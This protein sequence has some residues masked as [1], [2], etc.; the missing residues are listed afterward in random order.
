MKGCCNIPVVLHGLRA[1]GCVC[2]EVTVK[3][4]EVWAGWVGKGLC[5]EL[6]AA[7][8]SDAALKSSTPLQ[9]WEETVIVQ[10]GSPPTCQQ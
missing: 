8:Q 1:Q 2:R 7:L 3:A 9:A 6:Q 10:V 4:Y 5:M